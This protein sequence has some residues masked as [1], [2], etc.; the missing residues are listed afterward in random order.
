MKMRILGVVLLI[1]G[2]CTLGYGISFSSG[3]KDT[4]NSVTVESADELE[5]VYGK[6]YINGNTSKSCIELYDDGTMSFDGGEK[7]AYEMK[8]WK[9]MTD[10][11]S[12]G[13]VNIVN[14]YFL[15]SEKG[16]CEYDNAEKV[17]IYNGRYY[18]CV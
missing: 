2:F 7:L 5:L 8:V 16:M 1:A 3:A 12:S 4:A 17:I 10:T 11:D 14:Q 15:G 6:Y 13:R 18:V 9:N